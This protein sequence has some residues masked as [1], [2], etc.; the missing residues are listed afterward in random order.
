MKQTNPYRLFKTITD[1]S[2]I[3]LNYSNVFARG[4]AFL[5][6][7]TFA[8]VACVPL[9]IY[10]M[11]RFVT[12]V[13]QGRFLLPFYHFWFAPISVLA[14]FLIWFVCA[15]L[16][17]SFFRGT[18]GKWLTGSAVVTGLGNRV[19]FGKALSRQVIKYNFM[20]LVAVF[21]FVN[22]EIFSKL[23]LYVSLPIIAFNLYLILFHSEK[24]AFHDITS[25]TYVVQRIKSKVI[26]P[27]LALAVSLYVANFTVLWIRDKVVLEAMHMLPRET[28]HA[29]VA[30][31]VKGEKSVVIDVGHHDLTSA[32][33]DRN[34]LQS[35]ASQAFEFVDDAIYKDSFSQDIK[36]VV[37]M[38]EY[39][40]ILNDKG[41]TFT[42]MEYLG[43]YMYE[44]QTYIP[45][46]PNLVIN[47]GAFNLTID[48]A[49]DRNGSKLT[50]RVD[51]QISI[52]DKT[53]DNIRYILVK[54]KVLFAQA[55]PIEKIDGTVTLRLPIDLKSES[56]NAASGIKEVKMGAQSFLITSMDNRSIN[57]EH[58]GPS[59]YFLGI[60]AYEKS[61]LTP[62]SGTVQIVRDQPLRTL[63]SYKFDQ[64]IAKYEFNT[65]IYFNLETFHFS[66]SE[67]K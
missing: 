31:I 43:S 13:Q 37:F 5:A 25:S 33:T 24:Q 2:E 56:V 19:S 50:S 44:F 47:P 52:E 22:M 9:I 42:T 66:S 65:A 28:Q 4:V 45:Y 7:I 18:P 54:K 61:N 30:S 41:P 46:V 35:S 39:K 27:A 62:K 32:Q 23:I 51:D 10:V 36:K 11:N 20:L 67:E 58:N 3:T 53:R 12:N 64:D 60:V 63:Y 1:E 17:S 49:Y 8:L 16:E 15:I 34:P 6:D 40:K 21:P 59:E 48:A 26:V 57:F 29:I 14:I 55:A 38:N